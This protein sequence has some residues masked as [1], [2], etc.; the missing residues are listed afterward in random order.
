M[1]LALLVGAAQRRPCCPHRRHPLAP[2]HLRRAASTTA[3][4]QVIAWGANGAGQTHVPDVAT[5]GVKAVAGGYDYTLALLGNGN[6][7]SWGSQTALPSAAASGGN[8]V[9]ISAGFRHNLA[10]LSSGSVVGWG[11][12]AFGQAAVP[13]GT[14]FGV[15]QVSRDAARG[16]NSLLFGKGRL[17]GAGTSAAHTLS[18]RFDRCFCRLR[19]ATGFLWCWRARALA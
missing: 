6:V 5:S 9:A 14:L 12:N 16:D 15:T 3:C 10:L 17:R 8:V 1:L 2:P 4:T 7:A 11:D 19:L 13:T 18:M